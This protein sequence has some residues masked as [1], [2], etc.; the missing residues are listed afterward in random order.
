MR[1]MGAA[2]LA[3]VF[4]ILAAGCK[5]N[6]TDRLV[7]PNVNAAVPQ[8]S[9]LFTVYDDELKTGGGLGF[10]PGGENQSIDL[11]DQTDP[12]RSIAQI[13]YSWNGND[14]LSDGTPQH[15]FAGFSLLVS[16]DFT[17][18]D[19]ASAKD[20]SGPGYT[21]MKL[22]V[23]GGLGVDNSL[24]IEGPSDGSAGATPARMELTSSELSSDWTEITLPVPA[25]DFS[26]VKVFATF[27]IQ[28]DQPPRTTNP[29][30]GGLI[31]LDDIRYV[32]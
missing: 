1:R 20:L 9:G 15:L 32:R 18:L 4:A 3:V 11:L 19:S 30:T 24:R 26:A 21:Q 6:I 2:G 12:R 16:D 28:Y 27:S 14:V 10:I 5:R 13:R 7:D 22:F 25:A 17:G 31:Y 29:G 8:S 23:R